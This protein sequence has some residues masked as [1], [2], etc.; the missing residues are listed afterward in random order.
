MSKAQATL[1][2]EQQAINAIYGG[3]APANALTNEA[4][5]TVTYSIAPEGVATIDAATGKLAIVTGHRR[6]RHR[7]GNRYR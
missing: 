3:E 1:A 7:Y 6:C 5:L 2:F 4:G